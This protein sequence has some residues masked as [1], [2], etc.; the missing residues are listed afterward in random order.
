LIELSPQGEEMSEKGIPCSPDEVQDSSGDL[1]D[2]SNPPDKAF[3]KSIEP[4]V[5]ADIA[6]FTDI[7]DFIEPTRSPYPII[8]K[9]PASIQCIDGWE[10]VE[11]A[12]QRNETSIVC[13]IIHILHDSDIETAIWKASVRTKPLAGRC[14]YAEEVR[15]T[16]RLF[17]MLDAMGNPMIFSHGGARRGDSYI[18]GSGNNIRLVLAERLGRKPQTISKYLQHGKCLNA[19]TLK[20]LINDDNVKKGFFEAIQKE[21]QGLIDELESQQKDHDEIVDAVS[22]RVLS[23]LEDF[24]ANDLPEINNDQSDSNEPPVGENQSQP[25]PVRSPV[26]KPIFHKHWSINPSAA[27]EKQPTEDE[28]LQEFKKI[29]QLLIETAENPELAAQ[30]RIADFSDLIFRQTRLIPKLKHV[31][32]PQEINSEEHS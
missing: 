5:I 27:P 29:G 11:Q 2:I 23:W 31:L 32:I 30:R 19:E 18:D 21:K 6:H 17:T 4:L 20:I 15:N 26:G 14:I 3:E 25:D 10:M 13:E 8:V 7:P 22:A 24:Q 9:S 16:Y 1:N 28:I 12:K